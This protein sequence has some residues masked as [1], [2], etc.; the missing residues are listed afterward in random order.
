MFT[1]GFFE[2][3]KGFDNVVIQNEGAE[4][5]KSGDCQFREN[6]QR[7]VPMGVPYIW[8]PLDVYH[9][10]DTIKMDQY[11]NAEGDQDE[12]AKVSPCSYCVHVFKSNTRDLKSNE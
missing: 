2:S 8:I 7:T 12:I 4:G 3:L 11:T 10:Q 9:S 6:I 5:Y 1:A